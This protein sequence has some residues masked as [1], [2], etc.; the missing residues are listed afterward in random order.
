MNSERPETIV[1]AV[2]GALLA[3]WAVWFVLAFVPWISGLG[4]WNGIDAYAAAFEPGPYLAWVVPPLLLALTFAPFWV[5]VHVSTPRGRR[6]WSLLGFGFATAYGA[7]LGAN[8]FVL[9][10][11]VPQA[12]AAGATEGLDLFVVGSPHSLTGTLEGVGYGLMGIAM[13][14][15]GFAFGGGRLAVW[16]R[17]LFVLNGAASLVGVV[18][19]GAAGHVPAAEAVSFLSLGVW[20]LTFPVATVLAAVHFR[21]LGSLGDTAGADRV[22]GAER[23]PQSR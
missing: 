14:F 19:L 2:T 4:A 5:A 11:F 7:I 10:T 13:L 20:A 15:G 8:Y 16:V 12:I 17:R 6:V 9:A 23:I 3:T 18:V 21:R 1:G 22:A